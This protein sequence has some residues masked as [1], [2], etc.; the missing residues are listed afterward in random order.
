MN[1]DIIDNETVCCKFK[2]GLFAVLKHDR[3]DVYVCAVRRGD[4]E[5]LTFRVQAA[6]MAAAQALAVKGLNKAA[7]TSARE[8][9][10]VTEAT[11]TCLDAASIAKLDGLCRDG[12]LAN[13][14]I[15][16]ARD[17]LG[18][19]V[20]IEVPAGQDTPVKIRLNPKSAGAAMEAVS[21]LNVKS[22]VFMRAAENGE[23]PPAPG[24]DEA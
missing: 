1:W 9:H 19:V 3:D 2:S 8:W 7:A 15:T 22:M 18:R 6:S 10:A 14:R 20:D 4:R 12:T 13:A 17:G 16:T 11:D 24:A 23:T 21:N 5:I